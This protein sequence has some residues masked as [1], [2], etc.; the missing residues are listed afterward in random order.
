VLDL[1]ARHREEKDTAAMRR[2]FLIALALSA[3]FAVPAKADM[4][5]ELIE[6]AVL[7]RSVL[8]D[9]PNHISVHRFRKAWTC[10][11]G[12]NCDFEAGYHLALAWELY[13]TNLVR[14]AMEAGM[15][16]TQF[17]RQ[18]FRALGCDHVTE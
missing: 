2:R 17:S 9:Q 5:Q 6:C 4:S 8:I 3:S 16:E 14:D 7:A 1:R 13:G 10:A 12:Y 15:S 18:R 11:P